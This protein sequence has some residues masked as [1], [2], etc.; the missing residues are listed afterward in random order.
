PTAAA[1]RVPSPSACTPGPAGSSRASSSE[2]G[3]RNLAQA[4]SQLERKS[5]VV[6]SDGELSAGAG[7]EVGQPLRDVLKA[8]GPH[9]RDAD[10]AG[11]S[12]VGEFREGG[13]G[14]ARHDRREGD[15]LAAELL[16]SQAEGR[17]DPAAGGEEGCEYGSVAGEVQNRLDAAWVLPPHGAGD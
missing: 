8:V 1:R 14:G 15:I 17:C 6:D 3:S 4:T 12:R 10:D 11:G 5:V 2:N 13:R 9:D 16:G 7:G